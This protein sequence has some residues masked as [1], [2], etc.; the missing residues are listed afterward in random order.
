MNLLATIVVGTI[1]AGP[2]AGVGKGYL[3]R[4]GPSPIRFELPTI[5][6]QDSLPPLEMSDPVVEVPFQSD[7][8]IIGPIIPDTMVAPTVEE[9]I[10]PPEN[11]PVPAPQSNIIQPSV[12]LQYFNQN[13]NTKTNR[14]TT[15]VLPFGFNPPPPT[16][17]QSSRATYI[18]E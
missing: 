1:L 3:P 18:K 7:T 16:P 6:K 10:G 14:D 4:V 11:P 15:V 17:Q 12:F 2:L 5:R 8:N 9:F 13:A